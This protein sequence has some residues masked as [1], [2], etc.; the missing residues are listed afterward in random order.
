VLKKH[1][2]SQNTTKP[3]YYKTNHKYDNILSLNK[4]FRYAWLFLIFL[5]D[6]CET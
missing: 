3:N 4:R 1:E 5:W 2:F 6:E